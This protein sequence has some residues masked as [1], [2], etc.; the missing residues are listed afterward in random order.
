MSNV[1]TTS[2]FL[3]PF[4]EILCNSMWVLMLLLFWPNMAILRE[5][6]H[7][8]VYVLFTGQNNAMVSQ[9][10]QIFGMPLRYVHVKEI[11]CNSM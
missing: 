2:V 1:Y 5:F 3:V 8:L 11:L 6:M 7:F 4:K 9:N 10:L